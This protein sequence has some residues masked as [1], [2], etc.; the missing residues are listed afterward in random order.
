MIKSVKFV[1]DR[2]IDP[3]ISYY[4]KVKSSKSN[5][6]AELDDLKTVYDKSQ[7]ARN[8]VLNFKK[9]GDLYNYLKVLIE[10]GGNTIATLFRRYGFIPFED[11][12]TEFEKKFEEELLDT[13]DVRDLKESETYN[14]WDIIF[15]GKTYRTNSFGI[16]SLK[17]ENEEVIGILIRGKFSSDENNYTNKWL[18]KNRAIYHLIE[19]KRTKKHVNN[20]YLIDRKLPVYLFETLS[21]NN[22]I[23]RGKFKVIKYMEDIHSV[24]LEKTDNFESIFEADIKKTIYKL[25]TTNKFI[26]RTQL[27][28]AKLAGTDKTLTN[29]QI[30]GA[31]AEKIVIDF[32]EINGY[33][34]KNVANK[35]DFHYDVYIEDID[36]RI[37]VKNIKNGYFFISE[38]EM[39]QFEKG[40]TRICF[41]DG[42][43]ILLSKHHDQTILLQS[44]F[45]DIRNIDSE[46]IDKYEGRYK[47]SDI[48]IGIQELFSSDLID[49]F[50]ILNEKSKKDIDNFISQALVKETT[51]NPLF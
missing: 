12:V 39:R 31:N 26:K 42:E 15:L 35:I 1:V 6:K 19:S 45:A 29:K 22:H 8:V 17:N 37:E 16:L 40:Y 25:P 7:G 46:L 33:I 38:N 32:F 21:S 41:V 3:A 10:S 36:L 20:T 14:T 30:S 48:Q 23:Y 49:D 44:I 11:I 18:D 27:I 28:D 4:K 9:T 43:I 34:A 5:S 13:S 2:T 51:E 47:A 24:E 50:I